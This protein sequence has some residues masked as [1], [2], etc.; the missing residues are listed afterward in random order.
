MNEDDFKKAL[1]SC[2]KKLSEKEYQHLSLL[3]YQL[4]SGNKFNYDESGS[5]GDKFFQDSLKIFLKYRKIIKSKKTKISKLT[6][7]EESNIIDLTKYKNEIE[8]RLSEELDDL[9][10]K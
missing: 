6:I 4:L 1:V 3:M 2:A 9:T 5:I 8:D 10:K 7:E